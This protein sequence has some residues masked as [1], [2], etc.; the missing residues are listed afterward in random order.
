MRIIGGS[1]KG[2]RLKCPKGLDIRPTTDKVREAVFDIIGQDQSGI[3]VLDLFSG[4][5]SL[6]I[7][8]LSRG[9]KRAV[10]ID[11]SES[12]IGIIRENLSSGGLGG[13]GIV[14]RHDLRK[15]LPV[16]HP[17]MQEKFSL[18]FLDPPYGKGYVLPLLGE[19]SDRGIL[20]KRSL[21]IVECAKTE[22]LPGWV[23]NLSMTDTRIY[24]D[25]QINIYSNEV[26]P[27]ANELPSTPEPSIP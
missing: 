2:R 16:K 23:G 11:L 13:F 26:I 9:A 20:E 10:F 21:V 12:S 18:I 22:A 17:A 3:S 1:A 27:C 8:C 5:G 24:G 19:L 25:T 15:G 4:T 6:G 7:E 14:L